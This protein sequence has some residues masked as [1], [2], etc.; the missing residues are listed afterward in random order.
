MD[1]ANTIEFLGSV[2]LFSGL[3]NRQK[4]HLARR[5]VQRTY[6]VGDEIIR[7]GSIGVGLFIV[8]SGEVDV[9]RE[10]ASGSKNHM[11]TIGRGEFFG[12]F[13]LIDEAPRIATVVAKTPIVECLILSRL[14]FLA[15]LQEDSEMPLV[16]MRELVGR[17]RN[18]LGR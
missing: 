1:Q 8:A 5:F 18:L 11:A 15:V 17:L 3:N 16:I 14:D 4:Q 9:I 7:Q 10:D 6:E 13:S 2:P 12:E